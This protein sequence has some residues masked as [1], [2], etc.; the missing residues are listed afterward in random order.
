LR[1]VNLARLLLLTACAAACAN[2]AATLK[3]LVDASTAMP[4]AHIDDTRVVGGIHRDL[5]IELA[6]ELGEP[7]QFVVMPRKRIPV[8]L[9]RGDGDLSCHFLPAWLPGDFDWT[10]PFMPNALVLL[11]DARKA[12]VERLEDLR[13]QPIGTVLGFAYP[14]VERELGAGFVRDDAGDATQNLLKFTAG[15]SRHVLT[16][17]VFL[18][19]QQRINGIALRAHEPLVVRRYKAACAV[20]RKGRFSVGAINRAIRRIQKNHRL[21]AIYDKYR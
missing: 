4:M 16:G 9:Q 1:I 6:R 15:H 13:G 10:E 17:E 3:I 18:R 14:D 8:V 2:A 20:S 19:Y 7:A 11:S 21:A 12:P 5:G